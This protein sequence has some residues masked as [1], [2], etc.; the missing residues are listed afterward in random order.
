MRVL[1]CEAAWI[2]TARHSQHVT[3]FF[4]LQGV[5]PPST[6]DSLGL[7]GW[8]YPALEYQYPP[9]LRQGAYEEEGRS[10]NHLKGGLVTADRVMTVSPGYA[11]E[12]KSY[13][14]GW[15]MEGVINQRAPVLNGIVNGIDTE[16]VAV[17]GMVRGVALTLLGKG[18]SAVVSQSGGLLIVYGNVAR[19]P[20]PILLHKD[21]H[22]SC[23]TPCCLLAPPPLQQGLEPCH[24]QAHLPDL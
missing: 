11:E 8:W 12:I 22:S 19:M 5:H 10:V 14:G 24:R 6:F 20:C 2:M 16:W 1:V 17:G 4:L 18:G 3:D 23:F 9:H 15:G 21:T 7:P 13:L